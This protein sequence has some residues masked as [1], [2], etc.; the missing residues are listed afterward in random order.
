MEVKKRR[1]E[2]IEDV[3]MCL[4]KIVIQWLRCI[5]NDNCRGVDPTAI[6]LVLSLINICMLMDKWLSC[7]ESRGAADMG[8]QNCTLLTNV[9]II[10]IH[11]NVSKTRKRK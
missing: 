6:S 3:K 9:S 1:R 2:V 11:I 5:D 8:I 10:I 4:V 7:S